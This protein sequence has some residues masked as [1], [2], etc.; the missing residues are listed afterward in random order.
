MHRLQAKSHLI[1][2]PP[3]EVFRELAVF[4]EHNLRHIAALHK[5]KEDPKSI[6]VV[7]HFSAF[8]KLVAIQVCHQAA[9]VNDI[10]P[11]SSVFRIGEFESEWLSILDSLDFE[12]CSKAAFADFAN[13]LVLQRWILLQ[14]GASFFKQGGVLCEWSKSIDCLV[15]LYQKCAECHIWVG[16]LELRL[17][18]CIQREEPALWKTDPLNGTIIGND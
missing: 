2:T 12:N 18:S 7:I 8:D 1:K 11:L 10:L 5:L 15:G 13:N 6:L 3:A 16:L 17:K 4:V 9:L 14:N